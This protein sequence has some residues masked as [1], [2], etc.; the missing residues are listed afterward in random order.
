MKTLNKVTA[1]QITLAQ[2]ADKPLESIQIVAGLDL[3]QLALVG[4]GDCVVC[5]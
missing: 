3:D 5:W 2:D 4:G 1:T